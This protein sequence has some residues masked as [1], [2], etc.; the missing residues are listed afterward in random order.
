MTCRSEAPKAGDVWVVEADVLDVGV[1]F[2]DDFGRLRIEVT[3]RD[4]ALF[5]RDVTLVERLPYG[6]E[7]ANL[8]EKAGNP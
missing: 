7:L 2:S 4:S 3:G 8:R 6:D 5:I 1:V